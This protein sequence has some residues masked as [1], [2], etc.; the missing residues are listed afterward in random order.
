MALDTS[1][2]TSLAVSKEV[3]E[4][5][6]NLLIVLHGVSLKTSNDK[7]QFLLHEYETSKKNF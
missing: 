7:I 5:L 1:K 6:D 4:Q 3:K 2:N